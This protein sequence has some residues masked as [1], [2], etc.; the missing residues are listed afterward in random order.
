MAG[1][2]FLFINSFINLRGPKGVGNKTIMNEM[3]RLGI[4]GLG[5]KPVF[6]SD[7]RLSRGTPVRWNY[8]G[9]VDADEPAKVREVFRFRWGWGKD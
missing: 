8:N 1:Y 6:S 7:D 2:P 9:N 3:R 5:N 4:G